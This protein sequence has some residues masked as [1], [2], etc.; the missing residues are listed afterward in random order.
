[1]LDLRSTFVGGVT[2]VDKFVGLFWVSDDDAKRGGHGIARRS[3]EGV[4]VVRGAGNSIL[5]RRY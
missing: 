1:M 3:F 4:A 2:G 5:G